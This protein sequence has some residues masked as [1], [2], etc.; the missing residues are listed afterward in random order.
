[1]SSRDGIGNSYR[2]LFLFILSLLCTD[3]ILFLK[4]LQTVDVLKPLGVKVVGRLAL[5]RNSIG[6]G[7]LIKVV[8]KVYLFIAVEWGQ[9][10]LAV[11]GL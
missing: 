11:L 4:F 8:Y 2:T 5:V 6:A 10:W 9:P 1:M 3:H 7:L